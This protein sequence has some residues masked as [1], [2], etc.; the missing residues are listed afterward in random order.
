MLISKCRP[1]GYSLDDEVL[2]KLTGKISRQQLALEEQRK[3][4]KFADFH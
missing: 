4:S 1:K 2:T 3:F